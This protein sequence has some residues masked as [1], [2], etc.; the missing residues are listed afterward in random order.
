VEITDLPLSGLKLVHPRVFRD[1]R[2]FFLESFHEP[3]YRAAGIDCHFVQDNHARSSEGALRGLHFQST[4]GQAKLL[5]VARGRIFDVAV[6]IRPSSPTFGKWCGVYLDAEDAIQLF[7]PIGF[8]HGY[9]VVSEVADVLYKVSAVYDP[10]TESTI[11]WN[12]P[13]IAVAWPVREPVL[14]ERDQRGES[15]AAYAK[16]VKGT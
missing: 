16:R 3:R 7:I 12:D 2:G 1:S 14:S 9:C 11:Q 15:F 5:S 4:P 10:K 8:A 6:D 13:D